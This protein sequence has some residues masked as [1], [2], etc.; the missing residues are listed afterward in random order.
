MSFDMT[1][2]YIKT[3]KTEGD[4]DKVFELTV[5]AFK[6]AINTAQL[7]RCYRDLG[8]A[9]EKKKQYP[10]AAACYIAGAVLVLYT[11]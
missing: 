4:P 11:N 9:F 2:E 8:Y 3:Y 1:M 10:E 5:A 6:K 7:G